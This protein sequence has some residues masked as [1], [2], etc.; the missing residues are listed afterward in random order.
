MMEILWEIFKWVM[1][2]LG[3]VTTLG[4]LA[5]LAFIWMQDR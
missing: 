1:F 3:C 5:T 2:L 4:A